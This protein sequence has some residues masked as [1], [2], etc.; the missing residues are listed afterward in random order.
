MDDGRENF[1]ERWSRRK[2]E[3]ETAA[4]AE[5]QAPQD[6]LQAAQPVAVRGD[7]PAGATSTK[8]AVRPSSQPEFDLASL[9]SLDS[10]T[11][12][13]DIRAF[14]APGVPAELARAALRRAWAADPAIR[15]FVGLQEYAWDFTDPNG[16]LGF[17]ELPPGYD[18]KGLIARVVGEEEWPATS[19]QQ[20]GS[21]R[22]PDLATPVAGSAVRPEPPRIGA[23]NPQESAQANHDPTAGQAPASSPPVA[24]TAATPNSES[25][26]AES[27]MVSAELVH[28]DS[29]NA[30]HNSEPLQPTAATKPRRSHGRAL[31]R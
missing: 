16:V 7:A 22:P 31:P 26:S 18:V 28:R 2:R 4:R 6:T 17:G 27:G 3:A 24:M 20:T 15:D 14:L 19:T 8:A 30:A 9:P 29:V 23:A 5:K 1:L 21:P 10:I 11:A 12:A 13:T 25:I